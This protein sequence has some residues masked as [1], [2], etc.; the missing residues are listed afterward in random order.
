MENGPSAVVMT[1]AP[2]ARDRMEH[3]TLQEGKAMSTIAIAVC[4]SIVVVGWALEKRV[5]ARRTAERARNRW[6][7][8]QAAREARKSDADH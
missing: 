1:A 5:K 6:Q 7:D 8:R 4:A 2:R 3:S